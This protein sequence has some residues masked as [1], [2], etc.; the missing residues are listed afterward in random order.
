MNYTPPYD[1]HPKITIKLNIQH[2]LQ[3]LTRLLIIDT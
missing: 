3:L 1:T 2:F